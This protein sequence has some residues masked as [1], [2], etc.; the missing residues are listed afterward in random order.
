MPAVLCFSYF[1]NAQAQIDQVVVSASREPLQARAVAAD[2]VVIDAE[3]IRASTAD[4]LEDLLRRE[5]GLQLSRNGGP[6]ANAGLFIRGASSGQT[7]VLIDGMRVGSATLGT[8][9]FQAL[10]LAS[11][12]HIEVLRGPGSSLFGAD[13]LGGV[14]QLFTKRGAGAPQLAFNAALGSYGAGEAA[15]SVAGAEGRFDLAATLTYERLRGVSALRPGDQFGNYNPDA[16]GF[17]RTSGSAQVGYALAPGQRLALLATRSRLN[18]Q[19]DDSEFEPPS[20]AQNAAPDFRNRG[21]TSAASFSHNGLWSTAFSSQARLSQSESDLR[22]G[23]STVDRFRTRR[24]EAAA[25]GS[26]APQPGQQLTLALE[27]LSEKVQS[28]SYAADAQ[29][30]NQAAVLA[31]AGA[32]GPLQVQADVRRDDNS[33]Y[34]A[35][36]TGRLGASL[37][38]TDAWRVR[39]LAGSTF[40]APSFNDLVYPGYGVPS[41]K[42]E[43][44]R[45]AEVGVEWFD[46]GKESRSQAAATF[47]KNRVRDLIAYE[48]DRRFCP[49][50]AAYN[51]GCARNLNRAT[52]QGAT[53]SGATRIGAFSLRGTLDF[54][55]ALDDSTGQRLPRRAAN[56]HSLAADYSA[57]P[58]RLGAALLHVGARPDIGAALPASTTLDLTAAWQLNREVSLTGKLL[59]ATDRDLQP[60]RDYQTLGRQAW[61]GVRVS[62]VGL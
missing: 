49:P 36:N 34:G 32:L 42:P 47:F 50:D 13:A 37:A 46:N 57:G 30:R 33:V 14:V 41:V 25:Q 43:R 5:A 10:S 61:L 23:G 1:S 53:L 16:D 3:R 44:G 15:L 8:P 56:Q 7:L 6:G 48:S 4:S 26:W 19:Y 45:S 11:I 12:D 58:W 18:S 24:S 21:S 59:N 29:R 35:V 27:S 54:L 51:F 40:R 9:E 22:S 38:L 39:A 28:S 55:S 31:Y 62:G 2:V 52:L 20:Y 17:A 60:A